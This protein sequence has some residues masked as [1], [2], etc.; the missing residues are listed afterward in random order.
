MVFNIINN[1]EDSKRRTRRRSKNDND[2]RSYQCSTCGKAYLSYPALYTHVKSKH[3][4]QG[5]SS[6]KG[7]G[8]PKKDIG[9]HVK[10]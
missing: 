3:D 4:N 9:M 8:R 5:P 7:R 6:G 1:L 10:I 2:G